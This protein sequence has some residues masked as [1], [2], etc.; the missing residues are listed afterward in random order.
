MFYIKTDLDPTIPK[1]I[2][3]K[4]RSAPIT[5]LT[6]AQFGSLSFMMAPIKG[7]TVSGLSFPA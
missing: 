4:I 6:H 1:K 7:L 2:E 3:N 5:I